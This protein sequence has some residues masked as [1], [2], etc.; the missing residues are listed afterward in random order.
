[1]SGARRSG[2]SSSTS[3]TTPHFRVTIIRSS[4][5]TG[6][7]LLN[8]HSMSNSVTRA[9]GGH[10]HGEARVR[11][12][13]GVQV[14]VLLQRLLLVALEALLQD[15]DAEGGLL[16]A[17][18]VLLLLL[19]RVRVAIADVHRLLLRQR[20]RLLVV[21]RLDDVRA[22]DQTVLERLQARLAHLE[23]VLHGHRPPAV[24]AR[25]KEGGHVVALG[26]L[27]LARALVVALL[28]L[29][30]HTPTYTYRQK[31]TYGGEVSVKCRRP[32]ASEPDKTLR[33]YGG[34]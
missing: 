31:Q 30:T 27:L 33:T 14:V 7:S 8:V 17:S 16:A 4:T 25:L 11:A 6:G 15:V 2:A 18:L 9:P 5:P 3:L 34:E 1:M 32:R 12:Q 21:P 24:R 20:R 29:H 19:P 23:R 28:H 26:R 22:F 13:L 10:E